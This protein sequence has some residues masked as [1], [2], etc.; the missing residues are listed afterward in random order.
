[1]C[2]L[3]RLSVSTWHS[4]LRQIS[5]S[6]LSTTP[7]VLNGHQ[8]KAL[9]NQFSFAAIAVNKL[10]ASE[11]SY[12]SDNIAV[13]APVIST[14]DASIGCPFTKIEMNTL[15]SRSSKELGGDRLKQFLE[16]HLHTDDEA[17]EDDREP[18]INSSV[19]RRSLTS[20]KS[21]RKRQ[22]LVKRTRSM[23]GHLPNIIVTSS[24][25]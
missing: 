11:A 21:R 5:G 20:F 3:F 7:S 19:P 25:K 24:S 13:S 9:R 4:T 14:N 23:E 12:Q 17:G 10:T 8:G 6:Q 2:Y 1:M 18:G 15:A 16:N 22:H